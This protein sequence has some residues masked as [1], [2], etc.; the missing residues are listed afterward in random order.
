[1]ESYHPK[2]P[3]RWRWYALFWRGP[4]HDTISTGG[5]C[6]TQH[7]SLKNVPHSELIKTNNKKNIFN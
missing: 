4:H 5:R 3:W 6:L 1:V 7:I 2:D